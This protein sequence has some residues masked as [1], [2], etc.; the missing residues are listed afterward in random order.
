ME[1]AAAGEERMVSERLR[2]KMED[3]NVKAQEQLAPIQDHV[4]F[5]LQKAYFKCA[6]EC[7]DRKRRQEEINSCV[8][9]CSVPVLSANN[10]VE[11]EMEKFQ[12]RLRRAL[13]VCQDKYEA[14]KLHQT[15]SV[16]MR[17]LES[18]VDQAISESILVL[19]HIVD[20]LWASFSASGPNKP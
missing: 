16:A 2:R 13:M 1:H 20:R 18:C 7:F 14:A 17:S 3:V 12:E 19:P 4:N 10:L 8:E 5:T 9:Y 11:T 6:Y 15:P